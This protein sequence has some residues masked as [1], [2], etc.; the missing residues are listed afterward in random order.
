MHDDGTEKARK[1]DGDMP[2]IS[3]TV[4]NKIA[5]GDGTRIVC[6]NSDYTVNFSLDSEWDAFETKTMRVKY[7]DNTF[8]DVIFTGKSCAMPIVNN[9]LGVEIGLYAGNLHTTKGAYFD[10]DKSILY[11]SGTHVE[12][13]EDVYNQILALLNGLSGAKPATKDRLGLI[14]VGKNLTITED[15]VLSVDTAEAMEEDNTK[16]ITSA[17]VDT[18]VGNIATLLHNL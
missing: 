15:G 9:V 5:A 7:P 11:R 17:A 2:V 3:V 14:K 4:K 6:D 8:T 16:P 13:P 12:P 18:E 1:W 10:C